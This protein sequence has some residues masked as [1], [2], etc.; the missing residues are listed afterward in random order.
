MIKKKLEN[1]KQAVSFDDLK[2]LIKSL[3]L[4]EINYNKDTIIDTILELP[5][6]GQLLKEFIIKDNFSE[7]RNPGY[8]EE[9]FRHGRFELITRLIEQNAMEIEKRVT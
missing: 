9:Y 1:F 8:L 2:P 4:P 3:N 5:E 6:Y 7:V